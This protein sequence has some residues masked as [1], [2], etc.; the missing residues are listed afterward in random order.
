LVHARGSEWHRRIDES[1]GFRGIIDR[2]LETLKGKSSKRSSGL[3]K[4][5]IPEVADC[6]AQRFGYALIIQH[7]KPR[8]W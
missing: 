1:A 7:W 2:L 3:V 5:S 4:I 6:R 8:T